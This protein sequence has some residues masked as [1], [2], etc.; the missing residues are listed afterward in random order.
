[1][2][3]CRQHCSSQ[4]LSRRPHLN[5]RFGSEVLML[6]SCPR[7]IVDV[8][9]TNCNLVENHLR[10]AGLVGLSPVKTRETNQDENCRREKTQYRDQFRTRC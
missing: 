5:V 7:K 1:M 10:R 8:S 6:Q 2:K 4:G 9:S 3:V